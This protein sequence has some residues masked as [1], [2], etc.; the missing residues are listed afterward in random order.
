VVDPWFRRAIGRPWLTLAIDIAS[1]CVVGFYVGMERPNAG[2]VALLLSRIALLKA[3]WLASLAVEAP[4]PMQGIPKVLHMDNAAEFKSKALRAG[5]AQYGIE[6][7]YRPVG[8]PHFGGHIEC[9]NRTLMQRLKG[10]P[11]ATGNSAKGRKAGT[12]PNPEKGAALTLGDLERWLALEIG[13]RY[14][15]SEHRGLMGATPASA[16]Q[17]LSEVQTPRQLQP[18]PEEAWNWLVHFM[19]LT[20]RTVQADGVTIFHIRYWHAMFA[21]WRVERKRVWVRYHPE[22]LSRIFVSTNGKQY[23]EARCADLRH[24]AISLWEQ[25]AMCRILRGQHQ[26]VSEASIF[27]AIKLQ[28]RIVVQARSETRMQRRE[29][30]QKTKAKARSHPWV[31]QLGEVPPAQVD[32][33]RDPPPFNVEIWPTT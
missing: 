17:T 25:R 10:L 7:M 31:P 22:D 32:Y 30:P 2:T 13:M 1:R 15:H 21:A 29:S 24:P 28:R 6:L 33:S 23:L 20:H 12:I 26:P 4:W 5:C 27:Q 3:P 8:R 14:H 9:L 19:P 18:G 16:W 11:G